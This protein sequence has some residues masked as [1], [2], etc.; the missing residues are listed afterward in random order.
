MKINE[1]RAIIENAVIEL[2]PEISPLRKNMDLLF[3]NPYSSSVG[4]KGI[5]LPTKSGGSREINLSVDIVPAPEGFGDFATIIPFKLAKILHKPPLLIAEEIKNKIAS[6]YIESVAIAK[7]GYL[8]LT[9]SLQALRELF[10]ELEGKK[11]NLLSWNPRSFSADYFKEP[12][13]GKKVQV[14]FV[15]ANPTGPIHVGNGRGGIIGDV[16]S[17]VLD[18]RGYTVEREYYVNDAGS[19]MDLFARSIRYYYFRKC[20]VQD[21]FPEE[22]Y[23][24]KYIEAIAEKIFDKFQDS[25]AKLESP[26]VL[27]KIM[28]LGKEM[29]I[30]NIKHSLEVFGVHFDSFFY[31][32]S[33]YGG[34][35][36]INKSIQ[37]FKNSGYTYEAEGALWFRSTAFGDDKDRVLIRSNG[38]PTYALGDAA[39]HINKWERGFSK[40]IDVWGADHFGH[41]VPMKA[42]TQGAG[43]PKDF[44]D[45]IIYQVVHLYENGNEVMMS[46]HTGTFVTLDELVQEVGRDAAR[47]FFLGKSADTH[48]NFDMNLAKSQSM[49]NPV[50]YVQYTYARL[51][52]I[53]NEGLLRGIKYT[54]IDSVDLSLLDKNEEKNIL[55][56]ILYVNE[57][58]DSISKDYSVHMLPFITLELS[59]KINSFYQKYRVLMADEYTLPRLALVNASLTTLSFLFDLMGIEKIEKM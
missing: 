35:G 22:G 51:T 23:K 14:E 40:A 46:K 25:L 3:C 4:S 29:M 39:Y 44:L 34:S 15:S 43:M 52:N 59:Q 6:P 7:P 56:A 18:A 19:K 11:E 28:Q 47:F 58:L 45:V 32:S 30:E 21:E 33:L 27:A 38:E 57:E 10:K 2:Y 53:I 5:N 16:L 20:G 36:A 1:I 48:L 17:N 49:D 54:G 24:G 55:R 41:V 12:K 37:I 9:L 42:L 8:N 50:Y 13:N 31:E 26:D